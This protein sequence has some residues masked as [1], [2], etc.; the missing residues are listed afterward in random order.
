MHPH[1]TFLPGWSALTKEVFMARCNKFVTATSLPPIFGHS[2]RI[3]NATELLLMGIEPNIVRAQGCWMSEV[4]L[5]Y[6]RKIDEIL[7]LFLAHAEGKQRV[8]V[9]RKSIGPYLACH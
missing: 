4:F 7:P 9:L 3:G 2:F 6:W 5:E 1:L 8:A